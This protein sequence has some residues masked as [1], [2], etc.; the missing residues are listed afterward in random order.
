MKKLLTTLALTGLAASASAQTFI[1][2][3]VTANA[4]WSGTIILEQPIFVKNNATLT[5]LPGTIVR[6]QP[7]TAAV[8][9]GVIAGSPGALIVTQS[10]RLVAN[11]TEAQPI[12]FTTAAIDNDNNE[13]ADVTGSFKT[14]YVLGNTFLD[15]SPLA[16]PLAPLD[17]AGKANVALWG[18]VVILGDAPTNN[19]N[20]AGVGYGKVT[21]EG[22]TVPGFPAADCT[23]GGVNPHDNS[24]VLRYVSIRHAG[25]EIGNSNELNGLTLGGV[26]DGTVL[27]NIEVYTNFDD[28]FEWFGGTV[29]GKNLAAF[30]VGDDAFDIDEGYTG[31][32]QFL[33]AIA[34]FF[35][36]NDASTYGS[37]GGDKLGE[38]DG[39]NYRPDAV[40]LQDNVNIRTEIA[41]PFAVDNTP[42]PLSFSQ[43]WNFTG[44]GT[45]PVAVPFFTPLGG[46]PGVKRGIQFRNGYAG[47][48]FNSIVVN[49]GVSSPSSGE[50]GFEVSTDV[51]GAPGFNVTQ[52]LAN[53]LLRVAGVTIHDG[54]ALGAQ[55]LNAITAGNAY[56][57]TLGLT[58]A[59]NQN[60]VNS[61]AVGSLTQEDVS[62]DPTGN[63]SGKLDVTL[64]PTKINPRPNNALNGILGGIPPQGLGLE[65]V[66]FR[67]AFAR[68]A[69]KLWTTGW[70][71]LNKGGLLA[72]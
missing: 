35:R 6:G 47:N 49:T 37:A 27:E 43:T 59:G 32:N 70:T 20:K 29:N 40:A 72:D 15:D 38:F 18:G 42:W 69:P 7:R 53:G 24:G 39:D 57:A 13:I 22:L 4:T 54:Q 36:N 61:G 34:P 26:G 65:N 17:K 71:A 23:Y 64:R 44:I 55:E 51:V 8:Q 9:A 60:F 3:D 19:A 41:S 58:G 2:T 48:L 50:T 63:V 1:S 33:F 5:I 12:I 46:N 66:V 14:K 25:D 68:T 56:A 62:F 52:N 28:G 45:Q 10:G 30:F 16:A 31:S 67:G 11:G 21:V